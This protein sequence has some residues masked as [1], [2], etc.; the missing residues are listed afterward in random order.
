MKIVKIL[1]GIG[2]LTGIDLFTKY[3]FYNLKYLEHTSLILP[4][5]NIGI[6]RSL[7]VPY[8]IIISMSIMGVLAFIWL[9]KQKQLSWRLTTILIAGTIGNLRDRVFYQGVRD[10]INIGILDFPIFNVADM[11]LTIGVVIWI[12]RVI[13]EKKK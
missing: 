4:S 7:P 6:S 2:I 11:L 9:Y 3:L 12:G 1:S 13:L 8:R 5:F 10:F